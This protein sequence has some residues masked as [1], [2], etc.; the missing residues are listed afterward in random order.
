MTETPFHTKHASTPA[1][2]SRLSA[3]WEAAETYGQRSFDNY[4]Q[5][6]SVAETVRD[7]FCAWLDN[8]DEPCVYLV[9]PEGPFEAQN[10]QSGAFSVSGK[11]YLPL[12][13]IS[14]GLAIRISEDKDYMRLVIHCQK[15]GDQMKVSIGKG[16]STPL[17]LPIDE[18]QLT[19]LFDRIYAHLLMF[20]KDSV[21]Q[22]DE[23]NYG[24]SAI[25]FDIYRV[26]E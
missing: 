3:I 24:T 5:I 26:T 20:F 21:D 16:R 13:P 22:Y 10:Y 9:P 8:G 23:G 7:L 17:Q 4:A 1:K 6:R 11:G 25:G 19:P 2:D 18:T 14:F 12:K 15:E